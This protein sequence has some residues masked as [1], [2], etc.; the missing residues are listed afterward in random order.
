LPIAG[1][2]YGDECY[3]AAS[4][5]VGTLVNQTG[6]NMACAGDTSQLCGG[7][8]RLSVYND[9]AIHAPS[10]QT[11]ISGYRYQGCYTDPSSSQRALSGYTTTDATGMTQQRCVATCSAR[12]YLYAGVEYAREC[13]CGDEL[14]TVADG[15]KAGLAAAASCDMTCS[16]DADQLCGGSSLI[17]VWMADN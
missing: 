13:Y 10:V 15:G 7:R 1:V 5:P 2:E 11:E 8:S 12:N 17:G 3:C 4:L 14:Q 6:C 9:T 16:G